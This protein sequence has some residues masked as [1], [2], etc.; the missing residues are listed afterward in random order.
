MTI[1]VAYT[2]TAEGHAA[3]EHGLELSRREAQ[4]L[5]IFDLEYPSGAEDQTIPDRPVPDHVE[6]SSTDVHWLGPDHQS[7]DATGDLLDAAEA[8]DVSAIVVGVRRRSRVGKFLLG[9]MAQQIIIGANV[10]V[11][12]V[13]AQQEDA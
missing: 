3:L 5:L 1:L 4:P 11:I 13:K 7:P 9:S 8:R 12:A 6:L 10:P 2:Q